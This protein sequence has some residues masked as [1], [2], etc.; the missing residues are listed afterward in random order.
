MMMD[1]LTGIP[2]KMLSL[3]SDGKAH[4]PDE[5]KELLNDDEAGIQSHLNVVRRY[6]GPLGG[7]V[8]CI[9]GPGRHRTGDVT[10]RLVKFA[11]GFKDA[12]IH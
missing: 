11:R 6:L 1:E 5:L 8:L 10:Y 9:F 2:K 7:S 12:T 4:T 3:L